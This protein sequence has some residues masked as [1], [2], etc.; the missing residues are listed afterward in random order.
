M[1]KIL[2]VYGRIVS[3]A[4]TSP[5]NLQLERELTQ[6]KDIGIFGSILRKPLVEAGDIDLAIARE[7]TKPEQRL[8]QQIS[9]RYN[10]KIEVFQA[11]PLYGLMEEETMSKQVFEPN[12]KPVW[13]DTYIGKDFFDGIRSPKTAMK[14]SPQKNLKVANPKI[15][16]IAY[17]SRSHN[18][19]GETPPTLVNTILVWSLVL[20]STLPIFRSGLRSGMTGWEW[21]WNHTIFG[22][23][24]EYVPIEN[25]LQEL[26]AAKDAGKLLA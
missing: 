2:N 13:S 20:F 22:P 5:I 16:T 3:K 12:K 19:T 14:T 9:N 4:G 6:I 8:V 21:I 11:D 17:N 25:Y 15:K 7:L 24:V 10:K 23:T 18:P 26:Q 1:A